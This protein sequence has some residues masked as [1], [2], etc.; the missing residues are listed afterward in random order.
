MKKNFRLVAITATLLIVATTAIVIQ[1]CKKDQNKLVDTQKVQNTIKHPEKIDDINAYLRE[2]GE[3]MMNSKSDAM[4]TLEE[5][6]WHLT[7]YQ[8]YNY[9]DVDSEYDAMTYDDRV[10]IVPVTDGMVALSDLGALYANTVKDIE[11]FYK[12][13]NFDNK[14]IM[15]VISDIEESGRVN[16]R[17][18]LTYH[19]PDQSRYY[20]FDNL[21]SLFCD[22]IFPNGLYE[23]CDEATAAL[24]QQMLVWG[25]RSCHPSEGR[26]FYSDIIQDTLTYHDYPT[27]ILHNIELCV[28]ELSSGDMCNLLD[29]Y[30]GIMMWNVPD[31]YEPFDCKVWSNY[32][33]VEGEEPD[34]DMK[35][36]HFLKFFYGFPSVYQPPLD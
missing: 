33:D 31:G 9:G 8:N 21:S 29:G 16:M 36:H 4:L 20:Y 24:Q 5:A 1:S 19:K 32:E 11:L 14:R 7:A 26:I 12:N 28:N 25:P 35:M 13:S 23:V 15:Y 2:F 30:L 6:S 3:K 27:I 18:A 10:Y 22:S 34:T 17:T